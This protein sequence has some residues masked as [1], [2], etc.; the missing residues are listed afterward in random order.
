MRGRSASS[1]VRIQQQVIRAHRARISHRVAGH[2][3][4]RCLSSTSCSALFGAFSV[5]TMLGAPWLVFYPSART[6]SLERSSG[7][8]PRSRAGADGETTGASITP[9]GEKCRL[10]IAP[11]G[12]CQE[13]R[14]TVDR[15]LNR[16]FVS[17][18][19]FGYEGDLL[20]SGFGQA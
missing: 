20:R 2:K 19:E 15:N 3:M 6:C 18:R 10:A 4:E 12:I 5:R 17:S 13:L 16:S 1:K 11:A 9:P 14:P 8:A 7:Y